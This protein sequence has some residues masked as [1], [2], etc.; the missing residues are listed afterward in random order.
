MN[1]SSPDAS[2]GLA[3]GGQ[4]EGRAASDRATMWLDSTHAR[5]STWSFLCLAAA[6]ALIA[7]RARANGAFP[8]E[9]SVHFPP[10]ASQRILLGTNFGLLVSEDTGATWRYS[11]EPYVTTGSSAAL[12]AEN[13]NFYQITK[14]G[15]ILAASN[16]ITR[17]SDVG[18]TW[19]RSSGFVAGSIVADMF[20]D[21]ND[22][23]LVYAIVYASD[24]SGSA[25][26]ASHDGGKAFDATRLHTTPDLL[27]GIEASRSTPGV[28]YATQVSAAGSS[29]T[30]LRSTD[31]G[32]SWT[33]LALTA[34][35]LTTPR[36]LEV[37]PRDA[38]TVYLRMYTGTTDSIVVTTDGGHTFQT[39]LAIQ[40]FLTSFLHAS[41]GALYAG[42]LEGNLYVRPAGATSF[43]LHPGPRL[44]CLGQRPGTSR[45]Y[46]CGDMFLDGFSLGTSDDG[47][48]TFQPLM[49]FT[50]LKGPLTC[51]SVQTACAAH[52]DRIQQVLGIAGS[53]DAGAPAPDG[54]TSGMGR[55]S[56]CSSVGGDW[57]AALGLLAIG[58]RTRLR[59]AGGC[60]VE[61]GRSSSF[62]PK[63]AKSAS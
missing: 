18:C 19:P 37:D 10:N 27:K 45:V 43:T 31:W 41:D 3:S 2:G 62:T 5:R 33:A 46:A 15:V 52:W 47:G 17:S 22:A 60:S 7:P 16:D 29:P 6:F 11:C 40:G 4:P 50:D 48:L 42:M 61:P 36:I 34:S 8:D 28:V 12:S 13:V 26:V 59:K 1:V 63:L 21:P 39:A 49:K 58:L 55:G 57:V 14:D 25:I 51:A 44:R 32:A 53:A 20:P 23:T 54:G 9:F 30:L 56:N 24:G 35:A 38:N